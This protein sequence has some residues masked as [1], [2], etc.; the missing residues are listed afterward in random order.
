MNKTFIF[1]IAIVLISYHA[2]SQSRY[3]LKAGINVANQLK[4]FPIPEDPNY[5]PDTQPLLGQVLGV[6][7]KTKPHKGFLL[8]AELNF[9]SIGAREHIMYTNGTDFFINE[10]IGYIEIPLTLQYLTKEIYFGFG[11]SIGY[12][13]FTKQTY[14]N[15]RSASNFSFYQN[16][17]AASNFIAGYSLSSRIDLNVRYSHGHLNINKVIE[18]KT[19]NR[20]F[21]LSVLYALK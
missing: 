16:L 15:N 21:N 18:G 10:K 19:K 14:S 9:S 11:P 17:D 5:K 2:D 20:F 12:E 3:G 8:S 1:V 7:Y 4:V 13:M 6:Y